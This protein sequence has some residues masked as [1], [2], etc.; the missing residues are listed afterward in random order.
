MRKHQPLQDKTNQGDDL[1]NQKAHVAEVAF[2]KENRVNN[3]AAK[4]GVVLSSTRSALSSLTIDGELIDRVQGHC[5]GRFAKS[6]A[7]QGFAIIRLNNINGQVNSIWQ[8]NLIRRFKPQQDRPLVNASVDYNHTG[9][10][11]LRAHTPTKQ[12]LMVGNIERSLHF[13]LSDEEQV[14]LGVLVPTSPRG[15]PTYSKEKFSRV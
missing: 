11:E 12:T 6:A 4:P 10:S 14:T 1:N 5:Y 9:L 3:A 2:G 13:T 7:K 8:S 15:A